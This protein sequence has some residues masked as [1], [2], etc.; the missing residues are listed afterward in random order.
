MSENTEN[1]Q[2]QYLKLLMEDDSSIRSL[3]IKSFPIEIS[4]FVEGMGKA[5]EQWKEWRDTVKTSKRAAYCSSYIFAAITLHFT[6]MKLFI[7]GYLAPAG[8][9]QR[10]VYESICL[11]F[12]CA[13]RRLNIIDQI[14][15]NKYSLN[16]ACRD[17]LRHGKDMGLSS[18]LLKFLKGNIDFY[19]MY[20]HVSILTVDSHA[21]TDYRGLFI[22]P[23][24]DGKKLDRYRI[25]AQRRANLAVT[26]ADF[27]SRATHV[28]ATKH[29]KKIER[30]GSRLSR[31]SSE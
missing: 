11:A 14:A 4:Q 20:S 23:S 17:L 31:V 6:S 10:Q 15:E 9:T 24:F 26:F 1:I 25:E 30:K 22:G 3:Y 21:M 12:L 8:G 18:G 19:N 27:A 7:S 2:D 16:K 28:L 5:L 29:I 13:D